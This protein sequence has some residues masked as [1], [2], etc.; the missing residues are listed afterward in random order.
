MNDLT[1]ISG[2]NPLVYGTQNGF[3]SRPA[4]PG[5][6][7]ATTAPYRAW[8]YERTAQAEAR[9]VNAQTAIVQAQA[10]LLDAELRGRLNVAY[11]QLE[12]ERVH[13]AIDQ[14][15]RERALAAMPPPKPLPAELPPTP[16]PPPIEHYVSDQ[17]IES[18]AIRAVTKM[19]ALTGIEA[20]RAWSEWIGAIRR[21][22]GQ[23]VA[24]EI[25]EKA[26]DLMRRGR[27]R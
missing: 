15:K 7:E 1:N 8:S 10:H 16:V 23:F 13:A 22:Y 5:F 12:I 24:T 4:Q 9:I 26:A 21:T 27:M 11:L 6:W 20:D 17:A 25:E 18:E 19:G 14:I 2:G 3:S